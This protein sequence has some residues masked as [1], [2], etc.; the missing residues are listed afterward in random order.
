[1]LFEVLVCCE[2]SSCYQNLFVSLLSNHFKPIFGCNLNMNI[3]GNIRLNIWAILVLILLVVFYGISFI[4]GSMPNLALTVGR[5]LTPHWLW[6]FFTFSFF[7]IHI[8]L[9]ISDMITVYFIGVIIFPSWS[10]AEAIRFCSLCQTISAFLVICTLFVGY[11]S[12]FNHDLLW[13]TPVCGLSPL[14]G[15]ALVAARQLT[16]DGVLLA[17]PSGKFRTK[18]AT[19]TLILCFAIFAIFH[20]VTYIH[21]LLITFGVIVSWCYLRFFQKHT[22]GDVGDT[23]DGFK[24]SGFVRF[25]Y[26]KM[27]CFRFFPNHLEPPVSIV[28]NAV[29]SVLVKLRICND[30]RFTEAD[31]CEPM[32][33]IRVFDHNAELTQRYFDC[34]QFD[35]CSFEYYGLFLL[36]VN[37]MSLVGQKHPKASICM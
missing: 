17:L 13:K 25:I 16:P 20:V 23:T 21:L 7:N 15:G 14:L 9:L 29:Y 18:H 2:F 6:T 3:N 10:M 5:I 37:R 27:S 28:S 22:N 32:V 24:F 19:F 1:M 36:L 4:D 26:Y 35:R 33:S 12:T 11:A 8:M 34:S 30:K 31:F